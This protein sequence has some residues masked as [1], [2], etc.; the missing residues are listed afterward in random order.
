M[1]PFIARDATVRPFAAARNE[2][3]WR[4]RWLLLFETSGTKRS[5]KRRA[6]ELGGGSVSMATSQLGNHCNSKREGGIKGTND[7]GRTEDELRSTC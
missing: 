3:G 7:D 4:R 1:K 2:R 5:L 6:G